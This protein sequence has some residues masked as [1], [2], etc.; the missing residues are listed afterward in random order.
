MEDRVRRSK[1][2][3]MSGHASG[4]RTTED[5]NRERDAP[6]SPTLQVRAAPFR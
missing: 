3:D 5:E 1:S 6:A 2:V 4:R